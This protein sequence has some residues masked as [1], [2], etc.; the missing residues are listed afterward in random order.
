MYSQVTPHRHCSQGLPIHPPSECTNARCE[1]PRPN[2]NNNNTIWGVS[3]LIGEEPPPHSGELNHALLQAG[4]PT[5]SQLS[6]PASSR[7]HIPMEH[8]SRRKHVQFNSDANACVSKKDKKKEK[9]RPFGSTKKQKL[10]KMKKNRN[11]KHES[12]VTLKWPSPNSLLST[13]AK[14]RIFTKENCHFHNWN[15]STVFFRFWRLLGRLKKEGKTKENGKNRKMNNSKYS[16]I[17]NVFGFTR[18]ILEAVVVVVI[19]STKTSTIS[20]FFFRNVFFLK[21]KPTTHFSFS[22]CFK[23]K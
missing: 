17:S 15:F 18:K 23:E 11:E 16:N 4:D 22:P 21:E 6:R 3:V 9:R 20:M 2:N 5:Q 13:E 8:Q 10:E 12:G 7:H 14:N 1:R 19:F